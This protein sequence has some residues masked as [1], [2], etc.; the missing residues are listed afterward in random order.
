MQKFKKSLAFTFLVFSVSLLLSSNVFANDIQPK[1]W[2]VCPSC[3]AQV[4]F[5]TYS[6]HGNAVS[7]VPCQRGFIDWETGNILHDPVY[8]FYD[9]NEY[10]CVNYK[11]G[12]SNVSYTNIT[13]LAVCVHR[14]DFS[15]I[16]K[17]VF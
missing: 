1:N 14:Q 4:N 17:G 9:V 11:C 8:P 2:A 12:W 6:D 3:R 7:E 5:S 13:R 16:R 10:R 15:S